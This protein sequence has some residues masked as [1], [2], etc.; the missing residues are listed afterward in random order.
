MLILLARHP[1]GMSVSD[2]ASGTGVSCA[3]MTGVLD[4]L[5]KDGLITRVPSPEDRRRL[6]VLSTP[7]GQRVLDAVLP[8]HYQRVSLIMG[9][10]DESG[11]EGFL[12][13]LDRITG[14]LK[15]V[16]AL[17]LLTPR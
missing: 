6:V 11:R 9:G 16:E 2:L 15:K 10:L 13:A 4:T 12:Q 8:G 5:E 3:S 14:G 17:D 1:E 7:K